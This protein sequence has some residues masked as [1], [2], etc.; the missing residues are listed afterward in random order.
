MENMNTSLQNKAVSSATIED[1]EACYP[2]FLQLLGMT[3]ET[4]FDEDTDH[5]LVKTYQLYHTTKDG[6]QITFDA[7]SL[8]M[9]L[10]DLIDQIYKKGYHTGV[11]SIEEP[12][13]KVS[14]ILFSGLIESVNSL[15]REEY[16]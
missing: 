11:N 2:K 7:L 12:I 10:Q 5:L 13:K 3:P 9:T 8:D 1:I 6:H 16:P 4:Y 15:R 14:S